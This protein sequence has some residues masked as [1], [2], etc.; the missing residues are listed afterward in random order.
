MPLADAE[1]G[2]EVVGERV[3]GHVPA[4]PLL[5]ALDVLLRRARDERERGVAGVQVGE[6]R[7]LVGDERAAG[8][9][10][11]GPAGR[12]R[13]RRRSGRRSAGAD[14]RTGR[15]GSPGRSGPRT[16]Y[17]F[18]TA[19][20]GIR[21]RSAAS[22]SRARVSSFSLTSMSARAASHSWG[23][24]TGGVFMGLF[25][26]EVLIDDVE[27]APPQGALAI[28]PVGRLAEH[29]GL[30]RQPMRPAHD[31]APD[32]TRLLE[33]PQVLGDGGLGHAEPGGGITH[34]GGPESEPL[35]DAAPDRVGQRSE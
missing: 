15:A 34:R 21:R 26:L 6:V 27:Q 29:V 10:A 5:Q 33:H 8:A 11:L 32:H 2:V 35:H 28:H 30:E 14:P 4:H 7:D 12:R 16:A 20:H 17:S 22:A 31:L 23:E 19:I 3:P 24:T 13:A 1:V 25:L 9:A 18:S